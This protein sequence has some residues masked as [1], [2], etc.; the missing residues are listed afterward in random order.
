VRQLS[1][2]PAT[3]IDLAGMARIMSGRPDMGAFEKPSAG[4]VF[5]TP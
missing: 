4:T 2:Q 5:V 1:H 3:G